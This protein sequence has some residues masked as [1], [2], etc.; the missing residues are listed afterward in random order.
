MVLGGLTSD[1]QAHYAASKPGNKRVVLKTGAAFRVT[2]FTINKIKGASGSR[3]VENLDSIWGSRYGLRIEHR[4]W[5]F[6]VNKIHR[7]NTCLLGTSRAKS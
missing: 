4:S 1:N 6:L 5:P 7:H 2:G 3:Q